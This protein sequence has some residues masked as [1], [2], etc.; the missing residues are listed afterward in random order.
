MTVKRIAPSPNSPKSHRKRL[1][2]PPRV[3][4]ILFVIILIPASLVLMIPGVTRE[5]I[6]FLDA[7]FTATSA[8][9]VTGLTTVEIGQQ[10]SVIGQLLL[11]LMIQIGGLGKITLS[12]LI[13]SLFGRRIGL[14]QKALLQEELNQSETTQI[15]HLV[16]AIFIFAICFE[17]VGTVILAL[18]WVP[19]FGWSKGL[20]YSFFHAVSAF[21]N[22]GFSLFSDSLTA[23]QSQHVIVLTIA[24]LF[25]IGGI[26]YTVILD[27]FNHRENQPLHLH[28]KLT[29]ITTLILLI[30]GTAGILL[31]ESTQGGTLH[32]MAF[33]DQLVNGF[34]QAAAARTSGFNT[35]TVT[36]MHH[37]S[38][39]LIMFLM[40]IGAGSTSTGGG[41]KVSTFAVALIATRSFLMGEDK[42]YAFH[43]N[44]TTFTVLRAYTVIVI[45]CLTVSSAMLLMMIT[46]NAPFDIVMF[47]T[48]SAFSTVGF[49]T[50]LTDR[51]TDAGKIIICMV[52]FIGRLGPM[53]LAYLLTSPKRTTVQYPT[54][55]V[56]TG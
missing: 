50:G 29:L 2:S 17:L 15:L 49:T 54:D 25:I 10:F 21:N 9:T 56:F 6:H 5:P 35:V 28:T 41:I 19:E 30:V 36:A 48:L 4:L 53:T 44:I 31:L 20:Y 47:E 24:L 13:L 3:L 43:R 7:L 16:R 32:T 27:I 8:L 26:G 33:S 52:M 37:G 55:D 38:L 12:M 39:L 51:L 1:L 22:A 42:F 14:S 34:F 23:Y 46:E 40:F 45:S 18:V 11:L